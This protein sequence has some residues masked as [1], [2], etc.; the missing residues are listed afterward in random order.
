VQA[1]TRPEPLGQN[2]L[3]YLAAGKTVIAVDAGGP[4]EWVTSGSNVLLVEIESVSA[5]E[6][7]LNSL[8]G[9]S[10]LRHKLALGAS[11]TSGIG[12]DG[13]IARAHGDFFSRTRTQ[14]RGG[15]RR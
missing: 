9:D 5:L 13:E 2:V 3:Q 12:T 15:T 11:E 1:S 14:R 10:A 6:A 8:V 4:A 7:A